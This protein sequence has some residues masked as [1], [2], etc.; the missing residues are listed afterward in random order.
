MSTDEIVYISDQTSDQSSTW[1][2][3][4]RTEKKR[5]VME[6]LTAISMDKE[7]CLQNSNSAI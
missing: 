4:S 3:Q 2:P 5:C 6:Q 7:S 1:R